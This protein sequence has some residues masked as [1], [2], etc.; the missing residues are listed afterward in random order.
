M[1]T[2]ISGLG[3]CK[4]RDTLGKPREGMRKYRLFDV[5]IS[6]CMFTLV[7]AIIISRLFGISA[8]VCI[9]GLFGLAIVAHRLFCVNTAINVAIFGEV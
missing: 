3:L 6:D 5:A 8:G 2:D 1:S 7:G 9:V 4:Y